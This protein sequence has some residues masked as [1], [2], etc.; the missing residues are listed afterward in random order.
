MSDA[1]YRVF[2]EEDVLPSFAGRLRTVLDELHVT[3][4]VVVVVTFDSAGA[5][6]RR[7]VRVPS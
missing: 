4:E 5:G 3:Y 7:P 2:N 1:V 6:T